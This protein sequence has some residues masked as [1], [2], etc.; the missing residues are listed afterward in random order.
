[1]LKVRFLLLLVLAITSVFLSG[2][3]SAQDGGITASFMESGTYDVAAEALAGPFAE[4]TGVAVD[5]VA[6]PWAVLPPE[7]HH[8]S[9]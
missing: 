5:V 2:F 9:C 6:F 8:G 1:M 7:Q 3:A 4:E